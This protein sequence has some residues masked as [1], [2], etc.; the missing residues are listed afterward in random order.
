MNYELSCNCNSLGAGGPDHGRWSE[1]GDAEFEKV[2]E[3]EM[4]GGT[5]IVTGRACALRQAV[6]NRVP[7]YRTKKDMNDA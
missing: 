5:Q 1:S 2:P 6:C 3:S 7:I 4:A